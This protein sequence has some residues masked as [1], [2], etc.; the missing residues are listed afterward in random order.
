MTEDGCK[1]CGLPVPATG[2]ENDG[3][4]FCCIGCSEVYKH[5]G[6]EILLSRE[7]ESVAAPIVEPEGA[8]AYLRIEGMHCSSCEILIERLGQKIDGVLSVASS[9]ATSTAKVIYDPD[10]VDASRLPGLMSSF[11]YTAWPRS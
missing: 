5:F 6:P 4:A 10:R 1:L 7:A 2:V 11:G 8:E 9:Y 3:H